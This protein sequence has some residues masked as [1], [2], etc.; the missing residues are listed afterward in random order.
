MIENK[1][2]E[3]PNE[4]F[5]EEEFGRLVSYSKSLTE[6]GSHPGEKG[7]LAGL[8]SFPRKFGN[9]ELTRLL[10][11]G[12]LCRT[13]LA[14]EEGVSQK[15]V[16]KKIHPEI[17]QKFSRS[18]FNSAAMKFHQESMTAASVAPELCTPIVEFGEVDGQ[19]FYV[20]DYVKGKS[21][22]KSTNSSTLSNRI[23]AEIVQSTADSLHKLHRAGIFLGNIHPAN[24]ILDN[25]QYPHLLE[26]SLAFAAVAGDANSKT[27]YQAPEVSDVED[28]NS[29]AEIWSLG[30]ILYSCLVGEP[31]GKTVVSPRRKNPK[32]A[33][34]LETICLKCLHNNPQRRYTS[35]AELAEDLEL[36]LEYQPINASPQG[37]IG[38]LINRI[39][40]MG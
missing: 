37:L 30:A 21:L 22:A 5:E 2:F 40:K 7:S 13:F 20:M 36:F 25:E 23:S 1:S 3:Y 26:A 29:V 28:I 35:M 4:L 34:D 12:R 16:L 33:R 9:F 11:E 24:V 39:S 38:K 18:E 10:G 6:S 32:V 19:Y 15:L 8:E 14:Q 17:V 31:P 27:P